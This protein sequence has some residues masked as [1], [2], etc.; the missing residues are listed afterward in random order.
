MIR[1]SKGQ[2]V[3]GSPAYWKGKSFSSEY[4]EKL[5][6][7]H[8]TLNAKGENLP[9]L[10][11][12]ATPWNKGMKTRDSV[13]DKYYSYIHRWIAK[14]KVKPGRCERCTSDLKIEW[15]NISHEYKKDTNDWIALCK[16]CHTNYDY[17]RLSL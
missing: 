8:K 5:S 11:T 16:K 15:A 14:E 7:A 17:G 9:P 12:G 10:Q 3:K 1:N 2:F 13:S 6:V 4:K